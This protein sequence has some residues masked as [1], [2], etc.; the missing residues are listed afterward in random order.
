MASRQP[1]RAGDGTNRQ[2]RPVGAGTTSRARQERRRDLAADQLESDVQRWWNSW[3]TD[4]NWSWAGFPC[5]RD[6]A[7]TRARS[8]DDREWTWSRET[9]WQHTGGQAP[10]Q[11]GKG[12]GKG[13]GQ[14]LGKRPRIPGQ[15]QRKA[16]AT[17]PSCQAEGCCPCCCCCCTTACKGGSSSNRWPGW[18]WRHT[19]ARGPPG[20]AKAVPQKA[21][22]AAG[23]AA[24]AAVEV[25]K[26][27]PPLLRA[28]PKPPP[29]PPR[30]RDGRTFLV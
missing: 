25:P 23:R 1:H 17:G 3:Y 22:P 30:E 12:R 26:A 4:P 9:G 21:M 5:Q 28:T 15:G 11:K 2:G 7:A 18:D 14:G 10:L 6:D 16:L 13:R 29:A 19:L 8:R 24:R 20:E 27:A